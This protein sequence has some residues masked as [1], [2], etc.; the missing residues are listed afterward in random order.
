V[1]WITEEKRGILVRDED[2]VKNRGRGQIVKERGEE[3]RAGRVRG[4]RMSASSKERKYWR[5]NRESGDG[6]WKRV[7][8]GGKRDLGEGKGEGKGLNL[9]GGEWGAGEGRGGGEG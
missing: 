8:R 5:Q 9:T 7:G 6:G 1:V 2:K 3:R 4:E